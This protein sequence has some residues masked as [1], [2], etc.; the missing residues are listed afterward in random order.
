[1]SDEFIVDIN[2]FGNARP[3]T[4]YGVVMYRLSWQVVSGRFRYTNCTQNG[5]RNILQKIVHT[6]G[7][8]DELVV[9]L[10]FK[11]MT[12][13]HVWLSTKTIE[14]WAKHWEH[15]RTWGQC[16]TGTGGTPMN[17][18]K[19]LR[20]NKVPTWVYLA[21]GSTTAGSKLARHWQFQDI[22]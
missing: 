16:A 4:D 19:A 10:K 13:V 7:P 15:W 1:M 12:Q 17:L 11:H 18:F 9:G 14:S 8:L 22:E 2:E 6:W 3:V 21:T 20:F 5:P